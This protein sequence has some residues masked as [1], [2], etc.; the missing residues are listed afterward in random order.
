MVYLAKT[1]ILLVLYV[2]ESNFF[3]NN[4]TIDY[5]SQI[6]ASIRISLAEY[7][8]PTSPPP[9]PQVPNPYADGLGETDSTRF[10]PAFWWSSDISQQM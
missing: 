3:Y 7:V 10:N 4:G 6:P 2:E 8:Y 1:R 9:E 5:D